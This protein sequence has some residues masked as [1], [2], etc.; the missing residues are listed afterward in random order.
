MERVDAIGDSYLP[1]HRRIL[2]SLHLQRYK[3]RISAAA[4][5][6][7]IIAFCLLVSV[8]FFSFYCC[9]GYALNG[10]WFAFFNRSTLYQNYPDNC[11]SHYQRH[12]STP[13][14]DS[15]VSVIEDSLIYWWLLGVRVLVASY[16]FQTGFG[17]FVFFYT[18]NNFD[19]HRIVSVVVRLNFLTLC[20][21]FTMNTNYDDYYFTPLV[22]LWYLVIVGVMALKRSWN[23]NGLFLLAKLLAA[24]GIWFLVMELEWPFVMVVKGF[25]VVTGS[26]WDIQEWK[27][28]VELDRWV[29]FVGAVVGYVAVK[30][31]KPI[32]RFWVSGNGL[33]RKMTLVLACL[34]IVGFLLFESSFPTKAFL[35]HSNFILSKSIGWL[36]SLASYRLVGATFG[37]RCASKW[38]WTCSTHHEHLLLLRWNNFIRN[39][40]RSI[41]HLACIKHPRASSNHSEL[42]VAEL[43][44]DIFHVF[45]HFAFDFVSDEWAYSVDCGECQGF[46]D[47]QVQTMDFDDVGSF[48]F[49]PFASLIVGLPLSPF[50]AK[51][52]IIQ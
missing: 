17:H 50:P 42:L 35:A 7:T 1:L 27:F 20:L 19:L 24:A 33:V 29:V 52:S 47:V 5:F 31:E 9:C 39:L 36:Q 41:S 43:C 49:Q 25:A 44:I 51:F 45:V 48:G 18:K 8:I 46:M 3:I 10:G 11:F 37:V 16:L 6:V 23:Q 2:N 13:F 22:T 32:G 34:G 15:A 21:V 14:C 38:E 40:H 12:F 30:W 4:A 26:R 28:R